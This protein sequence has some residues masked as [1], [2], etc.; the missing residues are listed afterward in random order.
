VLDHDDAEVHPR[1]GLAVLASPSSMKPPTTTPDRI[2]G[3]SEMSLSSDKVRPSIAVSDM[4][5]AKEFYER[6]LGLTGLQQQDD[7]SEI[8]AC[9]GDTSL[10]VYVSPTRAGKATATLATW[11]VADVEQIVDELATRGVKFE[12]YDERLLKTDQKGIHT[13]DNGKVAWFKDPDG[14]TFAIEQ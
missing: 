5:R 14:N 1:C 11:S 2:Q 7:G 4:A 12:R 9:G 13:L 6:Q 8:Y 10:H 3:G